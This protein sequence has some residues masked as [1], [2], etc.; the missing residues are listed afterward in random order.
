M[1]KALL[2]AMG[3]MILSF[4][5]SAWATN[6]GNEPGK[7]PGSSQAQI[8]AAPK[9]MISVVGYQ[10]KITAIRGN[11]ITIQNLSQSNKVVTVSVDNASL[12]KVGQKVNVS[13]RLLTPR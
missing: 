13:E 11:Q 2:I 12:F 7:Y 6:I 1:R 5:P 4:M 10:A 3:L 9:D 8:T